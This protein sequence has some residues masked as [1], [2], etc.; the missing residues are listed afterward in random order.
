MALIS[1]TP[2]GYKQNGAFKL[3]YIDGE[4]WPHP[5]I[6]GKKLYVRAH[7]VLMCFDI[8]AH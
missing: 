8:A 4:S 6:D 3:P 5:A 1:A 2:D 7:D